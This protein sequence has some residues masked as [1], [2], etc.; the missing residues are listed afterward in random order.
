MS[1]AIQQHPYT[2]KTT[3][4]VIK[5]SSKLHTMN[6]LLLKP[7]STYTAYGDMIP[8]GLAYVASALKEDGHDVKAIDFSIFDRDEAMKYAHYEDSIQEFREIGG[9]WKKIRNILTNTFKTFKPEVVFITC[10]TPERFNMFKL[11][12]L[13]KRM[14]NATIVAGGPHVTVTAK[15]TLENIKEID[16]VVRGE[17]E[18]TSKEL[19]RKLQRKENLDRVD[20]ISYRN[21]EKVITNPNRKLIENLDKIPFPARELFQNEKYSYMLPIAGVKSR[22]TGIVT[23]RGCPGRCHF[24][25]GFVMWQGKYRTRSPKNVVQEMKSVL[26][27]YPDYDGFWIFDDNFFADNKRAIEICREIKKK[28]LNFIWGCS[29]RADN[30]TDEVIKEMKSVGCKLISFGI[31]SGSEKMLTEMNKELNLKYIYSAIKLCKK[32]GINARG[33]FIFG[34]PGETWHDVLKTMKIMFH[35]E[36]ATLN[37]STN[38][39]C[40]PGTVLT[41]KT[42]AEFDWCKKMPEDMPRQHNIPRCVVQGDPG[43][44][45]I[46]Q[47]MLRLLFYTYTLTHPDYAIRYFKK[48][49]SHKAF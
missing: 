35:F 32:N 6:I 10:N 45:K 38:V 30:I 46:L 2:N 17:G 39:L 16:I 23:S 21:K 22:L 24:C 34:Y 48:R 33:T 12:R 9:I 13:I 19:C 4:I 15:Q 31:E 36:P 8:I 27:E 41:Y 42:M 47:M 20:G 25:S 40:Y 37:Y 11:A 29:G 3:V 43:R 49:F 1:T 5:I 28:K 7:H 26:K 44:I 14:T 18:E